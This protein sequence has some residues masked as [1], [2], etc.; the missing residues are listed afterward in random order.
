M[1]KI[2]LSLAVLGL[3]VSFH[4]NAKADVCGDPSL[5]N[6]S[7]SVVY[8]TCGG[9]GNP[10]LVV[11]GW[12]TTNSEVPHLKSGESRILLNGVLGIC[13]FW[14]PSGCV[15]TTGTAWYRSLFGVN[16]LSK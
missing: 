11:G 4:G 5:N 13:P 2:I 10:E 8:I 1:K 6:A 16:G 7:S 9:N 12:G 15:D 14:F 3:F